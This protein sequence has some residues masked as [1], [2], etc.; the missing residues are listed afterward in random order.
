MS[1]T[2]RADLLAVITRIRR[3]WRLRVTLQG[4][5]LLLAAGLVW[6][7]LSTWLLDSVRFA[8]VAVQ[9]VR[10]LGMLCVV[11]LVVWFVARPLFRRVTDERIALYIEEHEP[12]LHALLLSAVEQAESGESSSPALAERVVADAVAQMREADEGRAIDGSRIRRATLAGLTMAALAALA[13][14]LG[15]GSFRDTASLLVPW[16]EAAAATPYA[17][18]VDPGNA[19]VAR[20]G[21]QEIVAHLRGFSS[22]R[23][24]LLLRTGDD[25]EWQRLSMAPGESGGDWSFRLFDVTEPIQYV[26]EAGGV[27]SQQYTLSVANLPAVG[28]YA[29]ELRFPSH[30]GMP[31]ERQQPAGDIVAPRGTT[32]R[33]EITPTM[34][35]AAGR[36]VFDVGDTVVLAPA[37]NGLLVGESRLTRDATYRIE[38][39]AADGHYVEASLRY[40]V[41]LLDDTGPSVV[42]RK[43]GRDGQATSVEEVY[44]EAEAS[45]DFGLR[46]L[47]L[48]YRVNGGEEKLV[49][50]HQGGGRLTE[51]SAGHTFFLE[52]YGLVPGDVIAYF[53]RATDNGPGDGATASS[54]IYF[55][56]IRPFGKE[57]RQAEQGGMP[58]QGGGD[59]PQGL[60]EQQKQVVAATFKVL[61][62]KEKVSEQQLREDL[63]TLALSEG[64]LR[65]RVANLVEEMTRR[66][67]ARADSTFKLVQDEL[68][69]ALPEMEAAEQAL[70]RRQPDEAL[71]PEQ[72]ALQHLQRAEEAFREVQISMGQGGGGGGGQS[73]SAED[74][75]DLFELE[76]DKLRNQYETVERSQQQQARQE[77]DETLERLRQLASRLQQENERMER[78]AQQLQN[79]AGQQGQQGQGGQAGAGAAQRRLAEEAEEMARQL[80]RLSREQQSPEVQ[81]AARQ[82]REAAEAMR[83]SAAGQQGSDAQ[84]QAAAERL[85]EATRA[86]EQGRQASQ[87]RAIQDASRRAQDLADTQREIARDVDRAMGGGA[88][89]PEAAR[90]LSERKDSLAEAVDRLESDLDRLSRELRQGAPEA[91]GRLADAANGIRDD[92]IRDK[93]RFSKGLIRGQSPEYARNFE[94]QIAANLDSAV[95]RIQ[96]A[97]QGVRAAAENDPRDALDRARRLVRGLESMSERLRQQQGQQ[98]TQGQQGEQD[99]QGQE[100]QP[101]Q[102]GQQGQQGQAGQQ[103]QGGQ[104]GGNRAGD[105]NS[106]GARGDDSDMSRAGRAGFI[107]PAIARQLGRELRDR[108]LSADTLRAEVEQLGIDPTDL[109][110]VIAA[111]RRLEHSAALND[112]QAMERLQR[113]VL[114]RL[115]AFEFALR[116]Q[117]EADPRTRPVVGASDQ[118]P[119]R[120]RELV[121]EYYRSLA[122]P[123]RPGGGN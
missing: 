46:S 29:V 61:R 33:F 39:R 112:P 66:G 65:E 45:D 21:D 102:Q 42:V 51:V 11:G 115:K 13:V 34:A 25:P 60:S 120:F 30:T 64:R 114:D 99:R 8:P 19:T 18:S 14:L 81:D 53:A 105:A 57:Y 2:V 106:P 103:G 91:G 80:E 9:I 24:E 22:E 84:G 16:R 3:R 10:G 56:K 113:D 79:R 117:F 48:V 1:P 4:V 15:P 37:E 97:E 89:S 88:A 55:L 67:S 20:G 50:L 100:G 5:A 78:A 72:R 7:L 109:E 110:A 101:G 54:D 32:A 59:T 76:T 94:E 107:D 31:N 63:A 58:G 71:P 12:G 90:G 28:E 69:A 98:G 82:L 95:S 62:D 68:S 93:I 86:L 104:A 17:V 44:V 77:V 41:D 23:V 40:R 47:E 36:L 74:L 111:L 87:T 83:R 118:V 6:L 27:R 35:T 96:G 122:R 52:E 70:G 92:R 43:P 38:L 116:R 108:R 119:P 26:V 121:E 73:S 75:A 123:N 49:A 85:R